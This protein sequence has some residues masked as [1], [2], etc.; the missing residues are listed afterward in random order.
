MN[1]SENLEMWTAGACYPDGTGSWGWIARAG[2]R[3]LTRSGVIAATTTCNRA[4]MLAVINAMESLYHQKDRLLFYKVM[5]FNSNSYTVGAFTKWTVREKTRNQ[6]LIAQYS[7]LHLDLQQAGCHVD[8]HW[9]RSGIGGMVDSARTLAA[10][11]RWS[12]G[13][14]AA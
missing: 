1:V 10:Q 14:V 6:D 11:A 7:L 9:V 12:T 3:E 2:E 13:A 8:I 5:I 4:E